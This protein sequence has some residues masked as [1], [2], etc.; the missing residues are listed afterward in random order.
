MNRLGRWSFLIG[1]GFLSGCAQLEFHDGWVSGG[2]HFYDPI[3]Y[4]LVTVGKDCTASA[5][6]IT[7]PGTPR[8]VLFHSGYGSANLSVAFQNGMLSSVG[9]QTDTKIP[10][11][12]TALTGLATAVTP[13]FAAAPKATTCPPRAVLYPIDA[14]GRPESQ[15][16]IPLPLP[17]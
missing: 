17:K 5:S 16:P 10:E 14:Q 15:K 3:P 6:V 2:A 13:K 9:Q 1:V 11:T 8:T 12:I 7:V 4:V